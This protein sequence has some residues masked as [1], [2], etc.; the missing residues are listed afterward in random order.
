MN[1]QT[2]E[3][4]MSQRFYHDDLLDE[5]GDDLERIFGPIEERTKGLTSL[6]GQPDG[7]L[8]AL[9]RGLRTKVIDCA[10]F[11][12]KR[13]P[14]LNVVK[15]V[16]RVMRDSVN[17]ETGKSIFMGTIFRTLLKKNVYK[18]QKNLIGQT[19]ILIIMY[20]VTLMLHTSLKIS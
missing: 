8:K 3:A 10:G 12:P 6:A 11:M 1:R 19:F 14:F 9:V 18:V 17:T 5:F 4:N 16:L 20:N 2:M 13:Q 15:E 7:D